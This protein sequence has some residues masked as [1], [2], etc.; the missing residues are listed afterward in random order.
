MGFIPN[1]PESLIGRSD[2]KN[3]E[4]TCRGITGSGRPCRRPLASSP[5]P[6]PNASPNGKGSRQNHL[7]VDDPSNPELYCHQHREQALASAKSSPGPR[8]GNTPILE[9]PRESVETL[10]DRLGIVEQQ[11][12]QPQS[13]KDHRRPS[14]HSQRPTSH[15]SHGQRPPS[16]GQAAPYGGNEKIEQHDPAPFQSRPSRR[17]TR[18]RLLFGYCCCFRIPIVEDEQPSRPAPRPVQ[19]YE[20]ES[21][22]H[23]PERPTSNHQ[24][25]RPS[26][27]VRPS[28]SA[29]PS[30]A[31]AARPSLAAS[32]PAQVNSTGSETS[33][34]LSLIPASASPETASH[35]MAEMAKPISKTDEAGYIYIFWLTPESEQADEPAEAARSLLAPPTAGRQR[36][37]SDVL[38]SYATKRSPA[39]GATNKNKTIL[40]KIG[41]ANNVQRRLNEWKRQCGFNISLIRYYP[42]VSSNAPSEPRKMPHSHKVER[43]I[44]I[45]LEGLGMRVSDKGNCESCGRAHKEWFEVDANRKGIEMVDEVV[46]RWSDWDEARG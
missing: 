25:L 37:T 31:A 27:A 16:H 28:S 14:S 40:L 33:Q 18:P 13:R 11:Q 46:R 7:R 2:S 15:A 41:R 34:Y 42:Y 43:L 26:S 3:P 17:H 39:A 8:M 35:L 1:T 20:S 24:Y 45:E 9:D 30:S 19:Y 36:R 38:E 23:A 4:T 22:S 6:S 44:H 5:A 10:M 21:I 29:R 32:A 12:Q